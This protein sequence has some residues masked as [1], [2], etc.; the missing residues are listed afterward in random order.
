MKV[1]TVIPGNGQGMSM[2]FS[3][4][5]VDK[6][7]ELGATVRRFFVASRTSLFGLL[8]DS[9][10]LRAEISTFKPDIIHVH[11]GTMTAWLVTHSTNYPVVITFHGSDLN[12]GPGNQ[13]RVFIGHVLS[14]LAA[15]RAKGIICV[16][17]ELFGR[18]R[19]G[20]NR[21]V[22]VPMG[23]DVDCFQPVS[24]CEARK[25]LGWTHQDPVLLFNA[26]L[27][28]T[29]KRLDLAEAAYWQAKRRIPNLRFEV[30]CGNVKPEEVPLYTNAAD[31]LIVTS[32]YEGSPTIVKEAM[33]CGLPVVSVAVGDVVERLLEVDPSRIVARDPH[34]LGQAVADVISLGRRSNGPVIAKRDLA[35]SI[36]SKRVLKFLEAC[37]RCAGED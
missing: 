5:Q 20:Q 25:A 24:P 32:D 36:I 1:L 35:E 33:A 23:V 6:I 3:R 21:A 13:L 30:L 17:Q 27:H 28:C 37:A 16:S 7:E 11:Y 9:F 4:R 34:A 18:L 12:P 29:V 22:V 10:R 14:Q 19:F 15:R 26:G 8:R 31:A 2:V